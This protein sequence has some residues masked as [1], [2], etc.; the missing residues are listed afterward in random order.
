METFDKSSVVEAPAPWTLKGQCAYLF[1]HRTRTIFP[2]FN[3]NSDS[4]QTPY[5]G[6]GG[7]IL[8]VK[9][10]DSP[11]GPYDELILFPGCY[12][13]GD[14]TFY[15]ISQIYVSTMESVVNGRRNWAVPKKL[16]R[17]EWSENNTRVKI[18]L[19]GK[20]QPFCTIQIR[21]RLYCFP[22][23]STLIPT[24]FRTLVQPALPDNGEPFRY[25]KITPTCSGWFRPWV[26]LIDFSTD[27][28]EIPSHKNL[29]IYS[30]GIGYEDF[31]LIFPEAEQISLDK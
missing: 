31:T 16:A 14:S 15:R 3:E 19:P 30:Y 1:L 9:Y 18:S 4:T 12:Q 7:G 20:E 8:L 29:P 24:S 21:P 6:G 25:F 26:Q 22:A 5:R 17:F 23:G 10:A 2:E 27:G 13:F 28:E 11:V